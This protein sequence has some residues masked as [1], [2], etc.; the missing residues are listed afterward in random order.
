MHGEAIA[1]HYQQPNLLDA[2]KSALDEAGH[3]MN[4]LTVEDLAPVD[5]FHVGGRNATIRLC[6]LL[7]IEPGER[8]VDLGSGI[9][10]LARYVAANH[11]AEVTGIDLTA[12]YVEAALALT[13]AVGLADHTHFHHGSVTATPFAD[14]EFDAATQLHVGMNIA[15]KHALFVEAARIVRPGGRFVIYDVMLSE[16]ATKGESEQP[17]QPPVDFPV[18]WATGPQLSH[19]ATSA[20]YVELLTA[21]GWNVSTVNDRSQAARESFAARRVGSESRPA[22]LPPLGLHLLMGETFGLKAAN[23]AKAI[24]SGTLAPTEILAVRR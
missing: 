15:D 10:G 12:D 19:L 23:L 4:D 13:A 2:I 16:T 1:D 7:Q 9:G 5:E 20:T 11:G 17:G 3:S 21:A 22:T 24:G 8:I 14:D 6:E 18:P